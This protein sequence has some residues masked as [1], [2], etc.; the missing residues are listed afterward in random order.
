MSKS[1]KFLLLY[2]HKVTSLHSAAKPGMSLPA[3]H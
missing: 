2:E 1:G 3:S